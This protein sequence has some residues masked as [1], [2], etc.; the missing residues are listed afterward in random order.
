M[1]LLDEKMAE[2]ARQGGDEAWGDEEPASASASALPA[3]S[4]NSKLS[5]ANVLRV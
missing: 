4:S 3:N 5:D 2:L 1:K